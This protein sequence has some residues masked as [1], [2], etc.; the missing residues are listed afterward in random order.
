MT[1]RVFF[2]AHGGTVQGVNF[3]NFA[4]KKADEYN[5]TGWVKNGPKETVEGEAQG[6]EDSI[7]QILKAVNDGPTHAHVVKLEKKEIDVVE[8][9]QGFEVRR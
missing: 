1:K 3:R 9:E 2:R 5:L 4:K 8:G 6:S 7:Q